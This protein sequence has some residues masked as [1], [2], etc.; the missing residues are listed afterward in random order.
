MPELRDVV[1]DCVHAGRLARFWD[2]VLDDYRLR[3]YGDED[4]SWLAEQGIDDP[5]DDPSVALDP[6]GRDGVGIFFNTVPDP[7]L[8]PMRVSEWEVGAEAVLSIA[9]L[10]AFI[11][12]V[13]F[14]LPRAAKEDDALAMTSAILAT[15]L[16][17]IA[18]LLIGV[19]TLQ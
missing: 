5:L 8:R 9:T 14:L 2:E 7:T 19:R 18:W 1:V 15:V 13:R 4:L 6:I 10:A 12:V 11:W 16:A 17:L 3:P